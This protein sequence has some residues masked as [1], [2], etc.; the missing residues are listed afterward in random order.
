MLDAKDLGDVLKKARIYKGASLSQASS[1]LKMKEC[2]L[3]ALESGQ[4][5]ALEEKVYLQGYIRGYARWLGLS[6]EELFVRYRLMQ[7]RMAMSEEAL[8]VP[9]SVTQQEKLGI[10]SK[11]RLWGV[12]VVGFLFVAG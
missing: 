1:V 7:G 5:E 2:Y 12:I 11:I 8:L 3:E 10:L 4:W 9:A 6:G